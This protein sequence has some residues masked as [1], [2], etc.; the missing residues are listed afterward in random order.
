MER[1]RPRRR[2]T[3]RKL[4]VSGFH[5]HRHQRRCHAAIFTSSRIASRL[6]RHPDR[7][8]R[9]RRRLPEEGRQRRD[10]FRLGRSQRHVGRAVH[11][12]IGHAEQR[13]GR[14]PRRRRREHAG[15]GLR[16]GRR[17]RRLTR[18]GSR[19]GGAAARRPPRGCGAGGHARRT[20]CVRGRA[21][22]RFA[23]TVVAI[24]GPEATA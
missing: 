24:S 16:A 18:A 1:G 21:H 19:A 9:G 12:A 6:R 3:A 14:H 15:R 2:G 11:R 7:G 5:P 8:P 23:R 17:E 13:G 10:Q 22:E 20:A 4:R